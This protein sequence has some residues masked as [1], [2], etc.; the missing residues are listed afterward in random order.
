MGHLPTGLKA[1][2]HCCCT[3][4]HHSWRPCMVGPPFHAMFSRRSG[5]R[6]LE[7]RKP[8][9]QN[10]FRG[11]QGHANTKPPGRSG[12]PPSSLSHG[13]QAS[14]ILL[15]VCRVRNRWSDW[16]RHFEGQTFSQLHQNMPQ[17]L[18]SARAPAELQQPSPSYTYCIRSCIPCRLL[19]LLGPAMGSS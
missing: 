11:L 7:S 6:A 1:A 8:L 15:E 5:G 3:P 17:T 10:R 18:L 4:S 14:Q 16:G 12:G 19:V 2:V 9:P 13:R